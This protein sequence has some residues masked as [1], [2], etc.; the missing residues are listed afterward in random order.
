[1]SWQR[2]GIDVF[3]DEGRG[4]GVLNS[5]YITTSVFHSIV[6]PPPYRKT[7]IKFSTTINGVEALATSYPHVR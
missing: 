6:M 3:N 7:S 4:L 2:S 1:M 5:I